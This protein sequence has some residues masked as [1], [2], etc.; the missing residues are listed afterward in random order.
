MIEIDLDTLDPLIAKPHMPDR[1][2]TVREARGI[3]EFTGNG[4]QVL[5]YED[6]LVL[7][8]IEHDRRGGRF[9]GG[10][11]DVLGS[12]TTGRIGHTGLE[13]ERYLPLL[14]AVDLL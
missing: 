12:W 13:L 11:S 7:L 10:H 3:T 4:S 14:G 2:V 8:D 1:V 6:K 5:K 9:C